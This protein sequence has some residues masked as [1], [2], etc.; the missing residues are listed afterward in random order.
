MTFEAL[1]EITMAGVRFLGR[2]GAKSEESVETGSSSVMGNL[3][4]GSRLE[5]CTC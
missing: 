1:V 4:S 3:A 2:L 5:N